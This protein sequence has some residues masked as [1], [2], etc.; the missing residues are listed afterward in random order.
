MNTTLTAD[1]ALAP[2]QKP[3]ASERPLPNQVFSEGMGYLRGTSGAQDFG[4][5]AARLLDASDLG[6]KVA[7]FYCGLLYFCG[8]GVTRN[9]QT[10]SEYA[11][12]YLEADPA[13]PFVDAARG[14]ADGSLGTENAKRILLKG[15]A[16]PKKAG[17]A[18]PP[19]RGIPKAA[20]IGGAAAVVAIGAAA[21]VFVMRPGAPSQLDSIAAIK[22]DTL[23][24]ADD[25]DKARKEA[26]TVAASLQTGAQSL[27]QERKAAEEAQARAAEEQARA[28]QER[29]ARE[30][31]AADAQ[32]RAQAEAQA[33]A[34]EMQR[35]QAEAAAQRPRITQDARARPEPLARPFER[36]EPARQDRQQ[37]VATV[38]DL[39][40]RGDYDRAD[41]MVSA[42]LASDP[43]NRAALALQQRI[44]RVRTRNAR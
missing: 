14:L 28:E 44:Q 43:S 17:P 26:L 39:I 22:L 33:R 40:E 19:A 29:V 6:H 12:R 41:R 21:V 18:Q 1:P 38:R 37:M 34:Q 9:A 30:Q 32:A 3:A 23:L 7:H 27:I 8:V 5:A 36:Q 25:L 42:V 4:M 13:G 10:A 20:L 2:Q 31:A 35:Q 24:P 16:T 15:P 11:T